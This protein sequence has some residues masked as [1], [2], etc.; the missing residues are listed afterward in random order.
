VLVSGCGAAEQATGPQGAATAEQTT[1]PDWGGVELDEPPVC[2]PPTSVPSH[3]RVPTRKEAKA[4]VRAALEGFEC[5]ADA[6][7]AADLFLV[8]SP[9]GEPVQADDLHITHPTLPACKDS[10]LPDRN[11][12]TTTEEAE[13]DA[14]VAD[15][16]PR[17]CDASRGGTLSLCRG[18]RR[19]CVMVGEYTGP[20]IQPRQ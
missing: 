15:A 14:A 6:V 3:P 2:P 7:L 10:H 17:A 19:Q 13:A 20:P 18:G 9:T 11:V 16:D 4:T 12:P 5:D 8:S 1:V